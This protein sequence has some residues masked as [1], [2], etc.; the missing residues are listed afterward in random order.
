MRDAPNILLPF[1]DELNDIKSKLSK[2]IKA[3]REE[4]E[5]SFTHLTFVSLLD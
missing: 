1:D 5:L 3:I 4:L 2:V